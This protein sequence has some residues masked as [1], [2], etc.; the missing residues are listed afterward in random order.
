MSRNGSKPVG[1]ELNQHG[2]RMQELIAKIDILP[3][4]NAR[5][6]LQECLQEVLAFYGLGL[7]RVLEVAKSA[8]GGE[9]AY[10]RLVRDSIVRG[11]LLIHGLHPVPLEARL[12]EALEKVR[13]L[14][15]K[16]RRQRRVSQ[17][18]Q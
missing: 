13:A 1:D 15:A 4:P 5:E 16:P 10:D 8:P 2:Q 18:G 14:Y 3:D 12:R 17:F 6:L 11:M 9:D 7:D